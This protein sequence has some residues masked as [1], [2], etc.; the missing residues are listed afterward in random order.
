MNRFLN[1]FFEKFDFFQLLESVNNN[2]W[3][4]I[5]NFLFRVKSGIGLY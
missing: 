5:E 3:V 1:Y 4:E 2:E